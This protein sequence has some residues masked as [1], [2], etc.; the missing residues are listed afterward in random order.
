MAI[1]VDLPFVFLANII[2]L[3]KVDKI[4][5]RFGCEKRKSVY[6]V[7][8]RAMMT[9]V[10]RSLE[11]SKRLEECSE[12]RI[13]HRHVGA[14]LPPQR[15]GLIRATCSLSSSK[16]TR[17]GSV[18]EES[19]ETYLFVG[20]ITFPNI[21]LVF[22]QTLEYFLDGGLKALWSHQRSTI[23]VGHILF[24]LSWLY[25][26]VRCCRDSDQ[27]FLD[28]LLA[29]VP[30]RCLWDGARFEWF[31]CRER[32]RR[33]PPRV[34]P[35]RRRKRGRPGICHRQHVHEKGMRFQAQHLSK[36]PKFNKLISLGR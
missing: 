26:Q 33:L 24:P 29:S 15:A 35:P 17:K 19:P 18:E 6:D 1:Y 28:F 27:F 11:K 31:P 8:L 3:R 10:S 34:W 22:V 7:D 25:P 30:I 9:L 32:G 4:C 23:I 20:P 16:W 14:L 5:N 13:S 2:L 12:R 21:L 36:R